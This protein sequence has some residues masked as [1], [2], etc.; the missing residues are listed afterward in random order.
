MPVLVASYNTLYLAEI[1]G[2]IFY[3]SIL[4]TTSGLS[5]VIYMIVHCKK[6]LSFSGCITLE[7]KLVEKRTWIRW[8]FQYWLAAR[9]IEL[10]FYTLFLVLLL[11]ST[12]TIKTLVTGDGNFYTL[13][14]YFGY[15]TMFLIC[16]F[17]G[18]LFCLDKGFIE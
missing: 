15:I 12:E 4:L 6:I 13:S 14:F 7:E 2:D 10:L 11:I 9:G 16:E 17:C 3:V 1:I 5:I 8:I 18:G